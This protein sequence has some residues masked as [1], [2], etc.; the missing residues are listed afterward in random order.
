[1]STL[2][3]TLFLGAI[4]TS[5]C[6]PASQQPADAS[7]A[8]DNARAEPPG[9]DSGP[10]VGEGCQGPECDEAPEPPGCAAEDCPDPPGTLCPDG[11]AAAEADTCDRGN[12]A[13]CNGVMNEG[14]TCLNGAVRDC[15]TDIGSCERGTQTCSGGAWGQ[16]LGGVSPR[17][18]DTCVANNDADCDG[19]PNTGCECDTGASRACGTDTGSCQR[20]VQRCGND[21]RWGACEGSVAPATRDSCEVQG[22]DDDCNGV[23]NEG[24]ACVGQQTETCGQCGQRTCDARRG[25][26]SACNGDTARNEACGECGSRACMANGMWSSCAGNSADTEACGECGVRACSASGDWGACGSG[27]AVASRECGECGQQRCGG[28]GNW[29]QCV[30]RADASQAC[31]DCGQ[32]ACADD[33][34]WAA[35]VG[36]PTT[37]QACGECGSQVCSADGTWGSCAGNGLSEACG[38]CGERTCQAGTGNWSACNGD[39]RGR[40]CGEC[41]Q[42]ICGAGGQWGPCA[43]T[44]ATQDCGECGQRA[45]VGQG[46]WGSCQG[47]AESQRCGE[48]GLQAC[49]VDGS[50]GE[51]EP[52]MPARSCGSCGEQTC[53]A[54]GIWEDCSAEEERL[55]C[56]ACSVRQCLPEGEYSACTALPFGAGDDLNDNGVPDCAENVLT[57]GGL[58]FDLEGWGTLNN[59]TYPTW[60]ANEGGDVP[61]RNGLALVHIEL[62]Q[63]GRITAGAMNQCVNVQAGETYTLLASAY[64]T[65]PGARSQAYIHFH[66]GEDCSGRFGGSSRSS[67]SSST[68]TWVDHQAQATIE[69]DIASISVGLQVR[70]PAGEQVADIYYDAALLLRSPAP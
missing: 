24:C 19:A 31:G 54:G 37:A 1:M 64:N 13:N 59:L 3:L 2:R 61:E 58:V 12:D 36:A 34:T 30:G 27:A 33:G 4:V 26:W 49:S 32:R 51:C 5:A 66:T 65:T 6:L 10:R 18:A 9:A 48:C 14:C 35:C 23:P 62:E 11:T 53:G 43:P 60:A 68:R 38:A 50:W 39:G 15:G 46:Q 40:A 8:G 20:G 22:A 44:D 52:A 69:D 42:E 16:C 57:N 28:D 17:P 55:P 70:P 67:Q 47:I 7:A 56:D 29:G 45:C 41:G 21:G 63:G 25:V